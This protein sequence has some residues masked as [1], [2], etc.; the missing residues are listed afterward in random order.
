LFTWVFKNNIGHERK[1]NF[2]PAKSSF[3]NCDSDTLKLEIWFLKSQEDFKM[4]WP[5]CP[6]VFVPSI[7]VP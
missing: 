6:L 7:V 5:F 3:K 2:V 1:T 4:D